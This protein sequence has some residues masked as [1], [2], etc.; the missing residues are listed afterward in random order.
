MGTTRRSS[1]KI[2]NLVQGSDDWKAH[3]REFFNASDAPAMLG[4]S[5]YKSRNDLLHEM[6]VGFA[7][8][9]DQA[10]QARFDDGH[11]FE[12]LARPL[13]EE[14]I[15]DDLYPVTG[16][17]GKFSASFDGITMDH[18]ITFEHKSL[19]DTIRAASCAAEL[20]EYLRVQME[21]Q[22]LVSGAQK[23]LFMASKWDASDELIEEVHHWYEH[24][25]ELRDKIIAGWAAFV[26]DLKTY[27]PREIK[28]APKADAIMALPA[29]SIQLRG[30]VA[31]SNLPAFKSAA[32][33]FIEAIK[34]D[35]QTDDDF[36]QAEATVK[37]C[38]TAEDDLEAAKKSALG[39]TASIDELMRTIDHIQEQLRGKRLLLDK[40]VKTEKE[41]RK[42]AIVR[43]AATAFR[44]HVEKLE[45][46]TRPIQLDVTRPDFAGAIKGKK[47]LA[48]MHDAVDAAL[49]NAKIEADRI[50][51]DIR[52]K[53][54]WC[55]ENAS[56]M[57]ALFPDLQ[58]IIVKPF[59]DFTLLIQS[60]I[61]KHKADQEAKLEIERERIR[62]EEESKVRAEAERLA[63]I[64]SDK[65]AAQKAEQDRL[66]AE[67]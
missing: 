55:K 32:D 18:S 37:F 38:K 60:R 4:I 66:A 3:R 28:E 35:L 50:A 31:F 2:M 49:T 5:P 6:H 19:N 8:E 58:Q 65:I 56:G 21:H 45:A 64:E 44:A 57:S 39:Q 30:E 17:L 16:T 33:R 12:A 52:K 25:A 53:L 51:Q 11:R 43:D 67:A 46:E 20:P 48:S 36:A 14:I 10:T 27:Q 41:A 40:L 26:D 1:M 63:K 42:E 62:K 15:G 29:L 22:F 61:D 24:D 59:G 13:A 34:T 7:S 47:T 23:C 54:V 9:V